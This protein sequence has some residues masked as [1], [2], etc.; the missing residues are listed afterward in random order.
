MLN[1]EL[2]DRNDPLVQQCIQIR[3][4]VDSDE[5]TESIL[6]EG[7][8]FVPE[9]L[10]SHCSKLKKVV[11]PSSVETIGTH[12]FFC[13]NLEEVEFNPNPS[14]KCINQHCFANCT[15]LNKFAIPEKVVSIA[16]YCFYSC[17]KINI[18]I[19]PNVINIGDYAFYGCRSITTILFIFCW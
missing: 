2:V 15:S 17:S 12:A 1:Y 16:P 11:I 18:Q 13:S 14:L 3:K 7:L 8:K 19:P 6:L 4:D 5:C 9:L 10:F